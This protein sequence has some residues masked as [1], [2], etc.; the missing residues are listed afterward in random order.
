MG[1]TLGRI[2][3]GIPLREVLVRHDV[4]VHDGIGK[5]PLNL[6][7]FPKMSAVPCWLMLYLSQHG[8]LVVQANEVSKVCLREK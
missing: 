6:A 7:Q 5:Q 8:V 3:L 4:G 2:S 1:F